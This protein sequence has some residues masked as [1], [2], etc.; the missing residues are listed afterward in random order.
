MINQRSRT[1]TDERHSESR[2]RENRTYGS[3]RGDAARRETNN[4]G[5]FNSLHSIAYSTKLV[6][7]DG[8][9]T[10]IPPLRGVRW[11]SQQPCGWKSHPASSTVRAGRMARAS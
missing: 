1:P 9:S 7:E 2:M 10:N 8:L 3:M 4:C 11:R 5:W 6:S